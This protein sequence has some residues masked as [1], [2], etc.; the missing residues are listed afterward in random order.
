M[1]LHFKFD[2]TRLTDLSSSSVRSV[3]GQNVLIIIIKT[4]NN[5]NKSWLCGNSTLNK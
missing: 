3:S 5:K 2:K 1:D 4:R